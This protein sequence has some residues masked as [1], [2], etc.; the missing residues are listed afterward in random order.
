[1]RIQHAL[2]FVALLWLCSCGEKPDNAGGQ[3]ITEQKPEP[4]KEVV[5]EKNPV[6]EYENEIREA[7]FLHFRSEVDGLGSYRFLKYENIEFSGEKVTYTIVTLPQSEVEGYSHQNNLMTSSIL[8]ASFGDEQIANRYDDT[9]RIEGTV[10]IQEMV[11]PDLEADVSE[12]KVGF[13]G[14]WMNSTLSMSPYGYGEERDPVFDGYEAELIVNVVAPRIY[15]RDQLHLKARIFELKEEDVVGMDKDDLG[16]LRNELF[17]R[18][19]HAFK[20]EKMQNYFAQ[21][22]WYRPYTD[23]ATD[24]LNETE[25][26]NAQFIKQLESRV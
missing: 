11:R 15:S 3:T 19:G 13:Y 16:Y 6:A 24:W 17:A 25:K 22:D 20:T 1:M 8:P 2:L 9:T 7:L 5:E 12:I 10:D 21:Q 4:P 26:R 18:H 23:D 14:S